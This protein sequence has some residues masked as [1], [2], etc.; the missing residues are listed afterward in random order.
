MSA[1]SWIKSNLI[2]V[3]STAVILI[4]PPISWYFSTSKAAK[5]TAERQTEAEKLYRDL[6]GLRTTYSIPATTPDGESVS[7]AYEPNQRVIEWFRQQ[8]QQLSSALG[9]VVEE[10]IEFNQRG[11][12]PVIDGVFPTPPENPTRRATL[13]LEF[14]NAFVPDAARP[15]ASVYEQMLSDIRSGGPVDPTKLAEQL[16]NAY[17]METERRRSAASDGQISSE[18]EKEIQDKLVQQRMASYQAR[19]RQLTV[20]AELSAF[21][22]DTKSA[23]YFPREPVAGVPALADCFRWQFDA[24][25]A[26]D[27]LAAVA[28]ANSSPDGRLMSVEEAPVK[29]IRGMGGLP[30]MFAQAPP[31]S[32]R[33]IW[34]EEDTGPAPVDP[35]ADPAT[36][37]I[38]PDF[39]NDLTGHSSELNQLYDVRYARMLLYVDSA[40]L[41]KVIEAFSKTNFMTVTGV[42]V[43]PVDMDADLLLGYFYGDDHVVQATLEIEA[44]YLRQW[45]EQYMP[46]AVRERLGL[47]EIQAPEGEDDG[48]G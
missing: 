14:A 1:I 36:Q 43:T 24:W 4:A 29:R 38:Q 5:I 48:G 46:P 6:G 32:E 3:G 21:P 37:V 25:L 30:P 44:L 19:A 22:T 13:L 34:E 42:T 20:Y 47:P 27:L 26:H 31:R 45:T 17:E 10:A 2:I 8:N 11:R 12:T 23:P 40:R 41:P 16:R 39:L 7:F 33:P 35:G 18:E 28:T 9:Q 15:G